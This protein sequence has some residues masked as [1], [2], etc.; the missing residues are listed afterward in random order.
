[1]TAYLIANPPARSQY[2]LPRRSEPT[3]AIVVH[4]AE[5]MID[6][7]GPDG[8]AEAVAR[9]I[10]RRADPGSY[11]A[12]ADSD[13]WLQVVPYEAEAFGE[14]TGGNRWALHLSF[15]CRAT[16]WRTMD[17][18]RRMD[19]LDQGVDAAADMA[20]WLQAEH[21]VTV[22]AVHITP[23]AYRS[24]R[25][26]FVG[27]GELD[28]GRRTDPG[29][30][31]PWGE[32]LAK[33]QARMETPAMPETPPY[34]AEVNEAL[35]LLTE[36]AGYA[37]ALDGLF[38]PQALEA[39]HRLKN[40]RHELRVLLKAAAEHSRTLTQ[41]EQARRALATALDTLQELLDR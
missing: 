25:A 7:T 41:I 3:G 18:R 26:G 11:H 17:D 6:V 5:S 9:F 30:R 34:A 15:A 28:P 8:G 33:F 35:Q 38:G 23:T 20:R 16:D 4:T 13:S 32:F 31:F 1:M 22:P 37:G 2:R 12:I 36:H 21:G 19:M 27:H 39:L 40:D 29:D 14:G 24:G 10:Q